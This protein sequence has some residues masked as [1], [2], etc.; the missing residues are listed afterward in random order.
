MRINK[1]ERASRILSGNEEGEGVLDRDE[2]KRSVQETA[3][4]SLGKC[5]ASAAVGHA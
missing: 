3:G 4:R 2:Q 1:P 5:W